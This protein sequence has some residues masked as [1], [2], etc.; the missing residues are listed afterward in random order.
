[1]SKSRLKRLKRG[2]GETQERESSRD[3]AVEI[4]GSDDEEIGPAPGVDEQRRGQFRYDR[5]LQ[6]EFDDFIEEDEP[7]DEDELARQQEER[8]VAR[9]R[10]RT[11]AGV[12]GAEAAGLD[13][14]TEESFKLAFGDGDDY[15]WALDIEREEEAQEQAD[16]QLELKD[17]FEQSQLEEKM[18]TTEDNLIRS[19][20]EPERFQLARK[21]F[22]HL[23]L[24]DEQFK[25][26]AVWIS[27]LLSPK[28][29]LH[30]ELL[31]PFQRAV[32]KVLEFFITDEVEVPFIFQHRKD[33]LIHAV[34]VPTSPDPFNPDKPDYVVS[35]EKLL[36][37]NDLWHVLELDLKFRA[38]VDK[39]NTLQRTYDRLKNIEGVQDKIFEDM[40]PVAV[41]ME[42]LSDLQ[43]YLYFQYSSQLK[44]L[45]LM[46]GNGNTR[47]RPDIQKS[48]YERVRNG[49]VYSV[50]RALGITADQIARNALKEGRKHYTEDPT[51]LPDELINSPNILDRN[52]PDGEAVLR[53]AKLTFAEELV[54]SPKMRKVMR[55]QYYTTGVMECFRTEKGLKNIDEQHAYYEF[56][57]LRNQQLQDLAQRPDMYLRMLKAEEEGLIQVKMKLQGFRDFKKRL[58]NDFASE[59]FSEIA[60]AWN[61]IREEVL[62]MAIAKLDKIIVKG[63][64]ETFK[65]SCEDE[66]AKACRE[67]FSKKLD[68]APYKPRGMSTGT[69]P[70]V[71]AL[72]HGNGE[73]GK[74]AVCWVWLEETG[75]MQE[76]GKFADLHNDEKSK[77]AFVELVQRRKPDVIAVSGF[78]PETKRLI[79]DISKIVEDEDLR[80]MEFED[81][82]TGEDETRRLEVVVVNDEVA[83]LY[84][85]S[86]RA[87]SDHP[88]LPE[89]ARYC[90]A[91]ARY[92]Q[93]PMKEY[94]ALG[95]DLVSITFHPAQPLVPQ[96]KVLKQLETALVDMVNLCGVEIS[97]AVADPTYYGNLLQYI[98]GLGPRKASSVLKAINLNVSLT[99]EHFCIIDSSILTYRRV[100]QSKQGTSSSAILKTIKFRSLDQECG[101]TV[102]ASSG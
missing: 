43:D 42:E 23:I 52:F 2:H 78:S 51:V 7:E 17:V 44:D 66:I 100:A 81:P 50:V 11:I 61:K 91:L 39:R 35:A 95:K 101:T 34:K 18:L 68:Q 30:R 79:N 37:Q 59:Y 14:E 32:G 56:K 12:L 102:R 62:D 38:L 65:T 70:R 15:A 60:D 19:T 99:T 24:T 67:E 36:N 40:I 87:V 6:G 49:N 90:V 57:Y 84:R 22:K 94:A 9:P 69:I 54:M 86:P 3:L 75:H 92:L 73:P 98:C 41:T 71:I 88:G 47:R 76:N 55:R 29:G 93:D 89:L 85:N 96:D 77:K 5:G 45:D 1:M 21:P 16:Q 63:V 53:A 46:N 82:D 4:F 27:N 20:D 8:E 48:L 10:D 25:E 80:G 64:K 58:L 83:R 33:Y 31:E 26:E 13:E 97:E 28:K 74:D 72:S